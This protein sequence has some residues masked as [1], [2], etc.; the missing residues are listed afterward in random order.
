MAV[1]S[2]KPGGAQFLGR[3]TAEQDAA[4]AE[5]ARHSRRVTLL[6]KGLP[7]AA[8]AVLGLYFISAAV[9]RMSF[10]PMSASV[11]AVQVSDGKLRMVNPKL[12]G[13]DRTRGGYVIRA[14]Y[15]DQNVADPSQIEL[16][17]LRAEMRQ[18]DDD[19]SLML[20][21]RGEFDTKNE[22]LEMLDGIDISTSSGLIGRME[23]ATLNMNTQ[24]LE[25]KQPVRFEMINSTVNAKGLRYEASEKLIVFQGGVH[26]NLKKR[27]G[28]ANG[29]AQDK[30]RAATPAQAEPAAAIPTE[31]AVQP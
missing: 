27:P 4:F 2:R 22:R 9:L 19:W 8:A 18:N 10:G 23:R 7:I 25:S 1:D 31:P 15:A 14:D 20:A 24:T 16:T 26:V 12:E 13:F 28:E 6:R 11:D 17:A 5:A 21:T 29:K 3:S 30:E